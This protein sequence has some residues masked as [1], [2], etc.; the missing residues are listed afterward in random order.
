MA[1]ACL[2]RGLSRGNVL[3]S[4]LPGSGGEP[5]AAGSEAAAEERRAQHEAKTW[6][7]RL[8]QLLEEPDSSRGARVLSHL[9]LATTAIS[10]ASF[11]FETVPS[12][13]DFVGW[14]VVEIGTTL[15][16]TA[17]YVL[18]FLVCNAFGDQTR[19]GFFCAPLNVLDLLAVLPF[20][21]ERSLHFLAGSLQP[22]RVLR[23]VRLIRIFRVFK[24]S[25]Y[26]LG[27][28]L[29]L[30]SLIHSARPLSVLLFFLCVGVA[31][32]STLLF[33]AERLSCPDLQAMDPHRLQRYTDECAASA[34][35][36]ARNGD[37]CC[38]ERGTSN[39][40]QS[41]AITSWWC[42]VTMTT[43]GY[44]DMVPRTGLGRVVAGFAMLSGI[45]L[46][47]LPVAVVGSKFQQSYEAFEFGREKELDK[48]G[49]SSTGS[50]TV[51][52]C[53][54]TIRKVNRISRASNEMRMA[55]RRHATQP[56]AGGGP[57]PSS[58]LAALRT[59]LK[60]L[61]TRTK[62][63]VTAQDQLQMLL[64][65]LEHVDRAERSLEHLKEKDA[66]LD[67]LIRKDFLSLTRAYELQLAQRRE[68]AMAWTG[69]E[70]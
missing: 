36:R 60:V 57:G 62:L 40:F 47:S 65:L 4:P 53:R 18:R 27:M 12:L 45:V 26:S 23:S 30:H 6:R 66:A 5:A 52:R 29:M 48:Q 44:G 38:N 49:R 35:G 31:L 24:L 51:E 61:E 2:S 15:I 70:G 7:Q 1:A 54:R 69:R 11:V 9:V 34:N 14:E 41:I 46:I 13:A 37:L 17:E 63:S 3:D 58:G 42:I 20:F 10:I 67:A 8:H 59:K 56:G 50:L 55:G 16:F 22:L 33:H 64:E 28:N 39:D 43:V 19:L 21:V 68:S 32:F 25:K